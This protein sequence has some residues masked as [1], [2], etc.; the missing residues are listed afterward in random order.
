MT[1]MRL[2]IAAATLLLAGCGAGPTATTPA[3]TSVATTTAAENRQDAYL[4]LLTKCPRRD[5]CQMGNTD[6]LIAAGHEVCALL[7]QGTETSV[8]SASA[9]VM[10]KFD[11]P[12]QVASAVGVAATETLCPE[13]RP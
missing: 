1:T 3:T 7:D 5:G 9:R 11:L 12:G 8:I 13:H 10:E 2:I 6:E 4:V